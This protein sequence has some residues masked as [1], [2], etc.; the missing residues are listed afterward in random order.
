MNLRAD[1]LAAQLQRGLGPLYVVH[2]DEPLLVIEA[3][4]AIRAAARAA[5]IS[6]R[7]VIVTHQHFRWDEFGLAAGN[8]SLFG[9]RKLV[10]LRIPNGKPGKQGGEALVRLA[11]ELDPHAAD[12]T[13]ISLPQLDWTVRKAAWFVA[14]S[15]AGC[16]VECNA[17]ALDELPH[18]IAGR[19]AMQQQRASREGLEFIAAHVEG[20]LLAAHQ[21]IQK[22]G[23]LFPAGELT[24]EQIED[25]VLHVARYDTEKLRLALLEGDAP[26]CA[27]LLEG[28]RGEG[29]APPLVLWTLAN[30]IRTLA[31]VRSAV[32]AGQNLDA[33]LKAERVFGPRQ[34]LCRRA[35]QR[36]KAGGLR[37]AL[38]HA[39]RIDRMIKGLAAGDIWDEFLQLSLRVRA[40]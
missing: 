6:E 19:L 7:E 3:A 22:L 13:L 37:A 39:A 30:E 5:G 1:Q 24:P 36:L 14:L 12:L 35:A 18:W 25:C 8:L 23:L 27:R 15:E 40:R 10:D 17:P 2:G 26:R 28:L 31:R 21:E 38:V 9:D 33:A 11:R 32:D 29:A 16:V 34:A 4:D 20:N